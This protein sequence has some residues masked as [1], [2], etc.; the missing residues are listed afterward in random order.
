VSVGHRDD[1]KQAAEA[2][3]AEEGREGVR[4]DSGALAGAAAG[5]GSATKV[6]LVGSCEKGVELAVH[7]DPLDSGLTLSPESP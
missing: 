1:L 3:A 7:G 2:P 5:D 4:D 6:G